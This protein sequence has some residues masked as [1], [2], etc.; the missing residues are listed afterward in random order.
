VHFADRNGLDLNQ[1]A[2]VLNVSPMASDV[3]RVKISKL[4]GGDFTAQATIADALAN[5]RLIAE[6]A[7]AAGIA[8]PLLDVC[9]QL[10]GEA[11]SLGL[12]AEDMVSVF[13]AIETRSEL[14]PAEGK[15]SQ[16]S[17]GR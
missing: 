4:V 14:S 17:I 15:A 7:R 5:N 11:L 10:Y 1:L 13:H 16:N 12:G 3:S 2:A 6:A 8:T 9:H